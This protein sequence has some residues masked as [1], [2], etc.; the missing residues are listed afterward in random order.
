MSHRFATVARAD[1][2]IDLEAG[3]AAEAG[4]HDEL[5]ACG[6]RYAELFGLQAAAYRD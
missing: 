6:G 5:L 1:L 2:I 3:R 4:S